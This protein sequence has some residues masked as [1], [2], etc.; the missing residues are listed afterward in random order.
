MC[1]QAA[2]PKSLAEA[3]VYRAM[4]SPSFPQSGGV[5]G[6][7]LEVVWWLSLVVVAVVAAKLWLLVPG[8]LPRLDDACSVVDD[9]ASGCLYR[10]FVL[11]CS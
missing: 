2:A 6:E 8:L 4:S 9:E 10:S 7:A 5:A 3:S 1:A 11:E